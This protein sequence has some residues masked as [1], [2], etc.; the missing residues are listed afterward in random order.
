[1]VVTQLRMARSRHEIVLLVVVATVA[2][3]GAS[4][5]GAQ[6]VSRLCL[7][8]ALLHARLSADDCFSADVDRAF[9][10]G[11]LYSDK[12]PGLSVIAV[13]PVMVLGLGPP[14]WRTEHFKIWLVRVWT[15]GIAF[16]AVVLLLGRTSE[17][18]EPGWGAAAAVTFG[19][20]TLTASL[21][22]ANFA[23]V[24]VGMLAFASFLLAS[25]RRSLAA[26]LVA[27]LAIVV[28]YQAAL[29][30]LVIAGYAALL[31]LRL[32]GRYVAGLV[33]GVALLGAYNWAA[34]GSPLHL[35]YRYVGQTFA[36][37][38]ASGFFGIHGPS[39]HAIRLVLVGDRGLLVNA[40][41][42]A[43]A[44]VG[45]ALLFR[46][47]ARAEVTVCA[48]V[49][50]LFLALEF[51]YYDP[52]GGNSPGPRFI[53]PALPF[54]AVGL[55]PAFSRR[56][57]VTSLLALA[58]VAASTA[59][60]LTRWTA[61]FS[62]GYPGT[63][64]HAF[65]ALVI[66]GTSSEVAKWPQKTLFTWLGASRLASAGIVLALA[67]LALAVAVRDGWSASALAELPSDSRLRD[68]SPTT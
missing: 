66:H 54:L 65:G 34:F 43:A 56:P 23:H 49:T 48:M 12:A 53:T 25:N 19:L 2:L 38:Q 30:A 22:A 33:P 13:P 17:A 41:V 68:T 29:P 26:G 21:A 51:G 44:A 39:L 46:R 5:V 60:A 35:S 9:F 50:L 11:H 61:N 55:A 67:I 16:V 32:L 27:G 14:R 31:G 57:V 10:G 40:P 62:G 3:C 64:W 24:A 45:L 52:Y 58:S 36:S 1:M 18:L 42:L 37:E 20:G 15:G 4:P 47:G 8:K 6:D 7:T 28:E 63:V 59:V